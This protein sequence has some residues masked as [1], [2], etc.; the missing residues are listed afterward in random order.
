MP[1]NAPPFFSELPVL[2]K[3]PRL[4]IVPLPEGKNGA[5]GGGIFSRGMSLF[6]KFL[7]SHHVVFIVIAAN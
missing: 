2:R 3:G 6:C 1:H 5:L 7:L 4:S